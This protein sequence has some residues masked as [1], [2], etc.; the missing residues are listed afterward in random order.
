M[1]EE[2]EFFMVT[3]Q[4]RLFLAVCAIVCEMF[5]RVW[6]YSADTYWMDQLIPDFGGSWII[7]ERSFT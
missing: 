6:C 2:V 1:L 4:A 5:C 3:Q 7:C